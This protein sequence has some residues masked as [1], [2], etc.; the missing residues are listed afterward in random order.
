LTPGPGAFAKHWFGDIVGYK[1]VVSEL[2]LARFDM[3]ANL[4]LGG[5]E[6]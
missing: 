5:Y 1:L 2:A 6:R 4:P 3:G